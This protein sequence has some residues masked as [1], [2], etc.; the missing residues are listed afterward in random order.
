MKNSFFNQ[1]NQPLEMRL[2]L[3]EKKDSELAVTFKNMSE[4]YFEK[5]DY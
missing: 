1:E 2:R 3:S 4:I 5:G